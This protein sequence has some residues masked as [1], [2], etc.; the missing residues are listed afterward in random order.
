METTG[1]FVRVHGRL[2][3]LL[4]SLK[5]YPYMYRGLVSGD[6]LSTSLKDG[7]YCVNKDTSPCENL[8]I[9]E[10][11]GILNKQTL[12]YGYAQLIYKSVVGTGYYVNVKAESAWKGWVKISIG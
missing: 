10:G 11:Y 4:S 3:G 2:G 9:D 6:V 5:L 8:P 1:H 7:Y 12:E